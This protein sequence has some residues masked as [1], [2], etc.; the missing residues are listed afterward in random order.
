ML[1]DLSECQSVKQGG[2]GMFLAVHFLGLKS[3]KM[4]NV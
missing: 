4:K 2:G 3:D 1:Q